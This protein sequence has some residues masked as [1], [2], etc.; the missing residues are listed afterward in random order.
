MPSEYS[1]K[2]GRLIDRLMLHSGCDATLIES[3]IDKQHFSSDHFLVKAI[4]HFNVNDIPNEL[5]THKPR[6][7]WEKASE[8]AIQA[9]SS[10]SNKLCG[11]LLYEFNNNR[12]DGYALY[13]KTVD[14]LEY[15]ATTCI[16]KSRPG[17]PKLH[18]IPMWHERI[19]P[20]KQDVDYWLQQQFIYGGPRN[21]RD[22]FQQQLRMAK[23]HYK[24]QLCLLR[25]E[26]ST[27]IANHTTTQYC[28]RNL[29][30]KSKKSTDFC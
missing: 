5:V 16:P 4:L 12:L 24:R 21:A 19:A 27:N 23:L 11:K 13:E 30:Q 1:H 25:R 2:S 18:N 28:F 17:G 10:L 15:A 9:Y 3:V 8:R 14:A 6:L 29:F 7:L 26:I 22:F 20:F